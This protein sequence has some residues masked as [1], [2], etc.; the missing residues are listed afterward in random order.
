MKRLDDLTFVALFT[1]AICAGLLGTS[2]IL[3]DKSQINKPNY[4]RLYD[5][6]GSTSR[7]IGLEV[8]SYSTAAAGAVGLLFSGTVA[9]I[10]LYRNR[11]DD[12][13]RINQ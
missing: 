11:R 13:V 9:S 4:S 8:A 2:A 3:H 7:K 12:E 6:S 1:S 5:Y 10:S